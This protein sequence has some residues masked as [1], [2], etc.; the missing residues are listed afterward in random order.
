M[1]PCRHARIFDFTIYTPGSILLAELGFEIYYCLLAVYLELSNC[2]LVCGHKWVDLSEY[3][4]GV[5]ILNKS[6]YGH[7][8][9]GNKMYLSLLRSPKSPDAKAD[10]GKHI[11][12]YAIMP[13]SK[14]FQQAGVIQQAYQLNY[15]LHIFPTSHLAKP[16]ASHYVTNAHRVLPLE[17]HESLSWF[18]AVLPSLR[19]IG[20][21][22]AIV[23]ETVKKAEDRDDC[24][25]VRMYESFLVVVFMLF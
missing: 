20:G 3:D 25:V 22:P 2:G 5:S 18:Q 9:R 13:H 16:G 21:D 4:W 15:P 7:S 24:L 6:K 19:A 1:V 14:T 23:I 8:V 10:M 11:I 12:T 17:M